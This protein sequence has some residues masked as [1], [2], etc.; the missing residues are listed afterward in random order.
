MKLP[1]RKQKELKDKGK[2]D[3]RQQRGGSALVRLRQF[4][5]QRGLEKTELS[6]PSAEESCQ[7][8]GKGGRASKK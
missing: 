8:K 1:A 5:K 6:N 7:D 2:T 3:P 4:E